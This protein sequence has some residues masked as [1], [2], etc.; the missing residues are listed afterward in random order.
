MSNIVDEKNA[1]KK[2]TNAQED[3][4]K[5]LFKLYREV[6][7]IFK[8]SKEWLRLKEESKYSIILMEII[9]FWEVSERAK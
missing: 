5:M 4:R 8:E 7:E 1:Y 6:K 2:M 9:N 3:E